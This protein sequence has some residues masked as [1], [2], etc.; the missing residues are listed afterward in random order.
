MDL[1]NVRAH[2]EVRKRQKETKVLFKSKD[3]ML[4]KASTGSP[5]R[6]HPVL[7]YNTDRSKEQTP[8]V[9]PLKKGHQQCVF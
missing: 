9:L 3:N 8:M 1:L 2:Q 7:N 6:E 5:Q 4:G